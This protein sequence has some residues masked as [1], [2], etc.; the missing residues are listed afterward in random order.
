MSTCCCFMISYIHK[1]IKERT[2]FTVTAVLYINMWLILF[3]VRFT[4]SITN[5]NAE[6][7]DTKQLQDDIL[8]ISLTFT[9]LVFSSFF[10]FQLYKRFS[11]KIVV[12]FKM[13]FLKL[14]DGFFLIKCNPTV[15][16]RRK[17]TTIDTVHNL[18]LKRVLVRLFVFDLV[19]YICI[20]EKNSLITVYV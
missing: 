17:K 13:L 20:L 4:L 15:H 2:S 16:F 6:N 5:N 10:K 8:K 19:Q 3:W 1:R 11:K 18:K 9:E 12:A 7:T 14:I